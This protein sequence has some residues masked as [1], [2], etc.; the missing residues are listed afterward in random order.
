MTMWSRR[1]SA[2]LVAR[3]ER[4][5]KGLA[6]LDEIVFTIIS[7]AR[8]RAQ[9][10][11]LVSALLAVIDEDSGEPAM[12]DRQVRDETVTLLLAGHE[13]TGNALTWTWY[14]LSEN[15]EVE[16]EL[17]REVDAL[18]E[19]GPVTTEDVKQL[20]FTR[21]V[22]AEALR[23]YPPGWALD[24]ET[25]EESEIGGFSIPAGASVL[26]CPYVLHR[27]ERFWRN[28]LAFD[29]S[30]W[31]PEEEAGRPKYCY[32]PFAAG[33]R[34]CVGEAFAWQEMAIVVAS[35]AR[36]W[37]ARVAAGH[38]VDIDPVFT[39]RPKDGMPMTVRQRRP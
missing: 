27:D 16:A 4:F 21:N 2:E 1:T 8:S 19:D 5:H 10:D 9:G 30:R 29:P 37:Q 38:H 25:L 32:L 11:D 13:T 22:I 34:M 36:R 26:V 12:S 6:D 15:P 7:T 33:V 3:S 20:Q 24:R 35:I 28:P 18:A 14:L 31:T 17:Y 23:L 39:L